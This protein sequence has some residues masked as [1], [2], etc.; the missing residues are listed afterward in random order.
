MD[1]SSNRRDFLK[2]TA[3]LGAAAA[4]ASGAAGCLLPV[5]RAYP[6]PQSLIGL[7]FAPMEKVRIGM[8]GMGGRGSSL[9]RDFVRCEGVEI[10]AVCDVRPERAE[11]ARGAAQKAG[12]GNPPKYT[13]GEHDFERLCGDSNVDLVI[14]A[15]PWEWHVPVALSAMNQGKHICTEVPAALTVEDCWKLVE[16]AEKTRRH[17]MMLENCC[18]GE[19]ELAVLN[20]VRQGA[21]GEVLH[22]EGGYLHDLQAVKFE[23]GHEGDWRRKYSEFWDG[24]NY[25]THGLGPVALAMDINRGDKFDYLVSMSSPARGL[26]LYAT[27]KFGAGD[28]RAT[29]N[30]RQGDVNTSLI[31]TARGKTFMV[32][33]QTN[34]PRPYSRI[35]TIVGTKGIFNGYPDRIGLGEQWGDVEAFKKQYKHPLWAETEELSKTSGHG[36]MDYVMGYRLIDCLRKGLPLDMTVYDAASWSCI[37]ELSRKSVASKSAALDFPDF[38]RG[39]WESA[40]PLGVVS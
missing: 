40:A 10:A 32:Q 29:A 16:T 3:K 38:T 27:E 37:V 21:F 39:K 28:P 9:L 8:V 14:T 2:N 18:Y 11:A 17:C 5:D 15:T 20:A 22:A 6:A 26:K 19:S 23:V 25:P 34:D 31:K 30:Y 36:G 35:N 12:R 1:T 13:N 4:L 33:H 24:N 7:R